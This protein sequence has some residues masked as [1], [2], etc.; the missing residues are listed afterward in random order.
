MSPSD[1]RKQFL[2]FPD[3]TATA[4]VMGAGFL[5]RKDL[6]QDIMATVDEPALPTA[7][8]EQADFGMARFDLS[9]TAMAEAAAKE[10][11]LTDL[12]IQNARVNLSKT[13]KEIAEQGGLSEVEQRIHIKDALKAAASLK[14]VPI[15]D[16]EV[17]FHTS[18]EK[19]QNN[20]DAVS[21]ALQGITEYFI[22]SG[23]MQKTSAKNSVKGF[24]SANGGYL[25]SSGRASIKDGNF[26]PEGMEIG[27][28][29]S[30]KNENGQNLNGLWLGNEMLPITGIAR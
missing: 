20:K 4:P 12:Q 26:N 18:V 1:I 21:Y 7:P 29:Y 10:R 3:L 24:I 11:E 9:K 13:T 5:K 22:D 23:T 17:V 19:F 30:Y 8:T 27:K 16:G 14:N 15:E 6:T 28:I 25:S 2:T